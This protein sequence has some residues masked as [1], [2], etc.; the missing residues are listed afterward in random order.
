M[1]KENQ[2]EKD[3]K[4]LKKRNGTLEAQRQHFYNSLHQFCRDVDYYII[5]RKMTE[6]EAIRYVK[7]WYKKMYEKKE[8]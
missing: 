1:K 6:K 4:K 2:L 8:K 3:I 5:D 7:Y